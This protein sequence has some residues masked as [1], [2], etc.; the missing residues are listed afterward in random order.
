MCKIDANFSGVLR[1]H[2][3]NCPPLEGVSSAIH[4]LTCVASRGNTRGSR[5]VQ[6]HGE[7]VY[8]HLLHYRLRGLRFISLAFN[9]CLCHARGKEWLPK[10][11]EITF[12]AL[13]NLVLAIRED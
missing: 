12:E 5:F 10:Y 8:M 13:Y 11:D 2:G 6:Q 4:F 1:N 3:L 9:Y 7:R